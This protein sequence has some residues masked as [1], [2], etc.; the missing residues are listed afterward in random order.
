[1]AKPWE[2]F[3]K[4]LQEKPHLTQWRAYIESSIVPNKRA[5]GEFAAQLAAARAAQDG[6][7][8]AA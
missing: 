1:L 4:D 7:A 3:I 6:G 8:E 5:E 2:E